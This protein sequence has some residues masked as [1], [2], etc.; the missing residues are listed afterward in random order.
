MK[1]KYFVLSFIAAAF[2]SSAIGTPKDLSIGSPAPKIETIE[3][4]NVVEDAKSESKTKES[5]TK[6]VSFWSPKK[7]AS[8]IANRKLSELYGQNNPN[9]EFISICT[10]KDDSLMSEVMKKD[11]VNPD[12]SFTFSQVSS[13]VFKDYGVEETPKAFEITSEGKISKIL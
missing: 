13:R 9:V 1:V 3:G 7:P 2:L 12:M 10:D 11:G 5:K 6:V 4:S 8:R